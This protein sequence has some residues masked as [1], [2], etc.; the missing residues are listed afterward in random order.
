MPGARWAP[1]KK[2]DAMETHRLLRR[3]AASA[4]VHETYGLERAPSTLAKLAVIGGGPVFRR[5]NRV[6]LYS[7]DDLDQWVASKLSRP[8][9]STSDMAS[10]ASEAPDGHQNVDPSNASDNSA[11]GCERGSST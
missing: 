5:M 4:Y 9:R 1:L 7:I 3:K 2:D 8:M 11:D 6:A 10:R